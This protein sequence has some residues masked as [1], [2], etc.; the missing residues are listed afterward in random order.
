MYKI[1]DYAGFDKD[2]DYDGQDLG[3][4]FRDGKTCFKTWS[5]LATGVYLNLYIDGEGDNLIERLPLERLDKGT[6]YVEILRNLDGTFYTFTYEFDYTKKYETVD[7]YAKACGINGNRGAVIDMSTTNPEGWDN[8]PRPVCENPCDAIICECHVRDF[9]AD[10]S[11]GIS[12]NEK[13]KFLAF[14]KEGTV[15]GDVSTCLD[16][17][18]ELGITHVQLLPIFDYATVDESKPDKAEYNW[19]YDPK[20]YNCLEGSYSTDA[21][22]PK[23]RIIEFKKLIMALHKNGIGVIMDVVYNHT[24]FTEKSAF[25][26]TFPHYYHRMNKN[27]EFSNGSGCGNETASEHIMMRRYMIS[28]LKYWASE[29]KLDG[30]RF[31]LMGLHDIETINTIRDE[32]NKFDPSLLMYGEGWSGGTPGIPYEKL[33]F[34]FNSYSIGR[35]GLFNDNFRDAIKGATFNIHDKGY[36]SGNRDV[37]EIIK[38]GIVGSVPHWQLKNAKEACW[39]FEPTQTIN[40]C[41][42][43]DNNTLW[44]KLAISAKDRSRQDRIKMD[45]LAAAIMLLAQGVPFIQL[46]QD[47]LRSKP[48]L[49]ADGEQPDDDNIFCHDSYNAPDYTN[50][51]KWNEKSENLE[52]FEYYKALVALRKSSALFRL[53]RKEEVQSHL[54]FLDTHDGNIIAYTLFNDSENYI[55]AYNPYDEVRHI[56][57]PEGKYHIALDENGSSNNYEIQWGIDISSISAL[58]LK[59]E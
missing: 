33:A 13:G 10:I 5:P 27:G 8:V 3:V 12:G 53:S 43:H 15:C 4:V 30:F 58:V 57:L 2:F 19:G 37:S 32:L 46:G 6:W 41:E 48:K 52:V 34:K 51:V 25:E 39:A 49:F 20:N 9:S 21:Y 17:L 14:T 38:R 11:S 36:V 16:H 40:Y 7:I 42:A 50:S 54:K 31:D 29:F 28:S 44:D 35:V 45:K 56:D 55:V 26:M 47:F 24:Y 23:C 18:K 1:T 22:D 59:K